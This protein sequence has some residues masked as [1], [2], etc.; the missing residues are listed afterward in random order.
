MRSTM[1]F[2]ILS[3]CF[4]MAMADIRVTHHAPV[5]GFGDLRFD[6]GF[7]G[8]RL[9]ECR[10]TGKD[11]YSLGNAPENTPV[12]SSPW[13]AFRVLSERERTI[14]VF[15]HYGTHKH[16]YRPKVSRDGES[17]RLMDES[18]Y[19]LILDE[20]AVRFTLRVGPELLYVAAQELVTNSDYANWRQVQAALQ[21]V[22]DREIGRTLGNRP[23]HALTTAG[24]A[25]DWILIVGRQHPPEIT[26]A[27]ALLPFVERLLRQD[28]LAERFRH[29]YR[30][31]IVPNLNPDGVA[32]GHW[33]HNYGGVDLNRDWG[34]FTQPETS[35]VIAELERVLG[36]PG[37]R[38][39]LGLDFHS[40][41]RDVFY[42]QEDGEVAILPDFTADWLRAIAHGVPGF[43]VDR[44]AS[45][46]SG[47]P[48]FKHYI[49]ET[50]GVPAITY[51]MGDRTDRDLIR[52]VALVAA[53]SMMTLLTAP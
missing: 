23:L 12:N 20:T 26:G 38:L 6:A 47:R 15:F 25:S 39:V 28:E 9:S 53:E 18:S 1:L 16:R 43:T 41:R 21:H 50:Y 45:R 40:T 27:L 31:L 3:G 22:E 5:C 14:R 19:R 49:S 32:S 8:A 24:A 33:R 30:L 36:Q 4:G 42:T 29:R 17:W 10:Q 48:V 51:E 46:N 37:Q 34:L 11:E 44:A 13:Y 2:L 35:A 7:E 52:R